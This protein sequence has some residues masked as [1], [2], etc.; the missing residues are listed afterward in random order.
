MAGLHDYRAPGL[1]VGFCGTAVS[2]TRLLALTIV[3][4]YDAV[5]HIPTSEFDT[6]SAGI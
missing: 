3:D 6:R 4:A 1:R 5:M 2:S